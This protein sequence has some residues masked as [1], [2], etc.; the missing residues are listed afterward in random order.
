MHA[1]AT[2]PGREGG[3]DIGWV[4]DFATMRWLSGPKPSGSNRGI[5]LPVG[6]APELTLVATVKR[7]PSLGISKPNSVSNDSTV[8]LGSTDGMP[9]KCIGGRLSLKKKT[10]RSQQILTHSMANSGQ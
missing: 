1:S 8:W 10:N 6:C 4:V 2:K 7:S 5:D 3:L 9:Q